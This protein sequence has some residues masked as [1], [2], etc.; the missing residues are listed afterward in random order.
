VASAGAGWA[1][2]VAG[3]AAP[4]LQA[5]RQTRQS[6]R[7]LEGFGAPAQEEDA[8]YGSSVAPH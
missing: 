1:Q 8:I 5:V 7:R 2:V 4:S 6:Q 3:A